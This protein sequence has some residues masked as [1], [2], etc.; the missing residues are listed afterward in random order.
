MQGNTL[1]GIDLQ[2]RL[3]FDSSVKRKNDS[4]VE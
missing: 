4:D 3:V 2:I 1:N